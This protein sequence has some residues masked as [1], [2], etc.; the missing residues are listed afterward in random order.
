MLFVLTSQHVFFELASGQRTA[1][2]ARRLIERTAMSALAAAG[3]D[4][5]A[6][7]RPSQASARP[8]RP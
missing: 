5:S 6:G 8:P 1:A 2:A 3:F 7:P 4:T